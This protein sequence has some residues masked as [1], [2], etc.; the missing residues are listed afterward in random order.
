MPAALA[1]PFQLN[2]TWDVGSV[3]SGTAGHGPGVCSLTVMKKMFAVHGVSLH[4]R[5]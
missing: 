2:Q 4:M 1:K 5:L 3:F